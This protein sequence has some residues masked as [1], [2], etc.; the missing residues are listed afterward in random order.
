MHVVAG[1]WNEILTHGYGA[2][3]ELAYCVRIILILFVEFHW[4]IEVILLL[5]MTYTEK[6]VH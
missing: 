2:V 6:P 1:E 3:D 5:G 4:A